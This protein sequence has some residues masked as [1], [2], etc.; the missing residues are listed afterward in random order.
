MNYEAVGG[1]SIIGVNGNVMI[2][3]GISTPLAIKNMI[4]WAKKQVESQ[5]YVQIAKALN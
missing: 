4:G 2:A 1:S 5:A 3:H